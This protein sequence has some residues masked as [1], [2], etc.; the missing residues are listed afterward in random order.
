MKSVNMVKHSS[1]TTNVEA[2]ASPDRRGSSSL[3]QDLDCDD[4]NVN[5][6]NLGEVADCETEENSIVEVL[7]DVGDLTQD[8]NAEHIDVGS[9]DDHVK[10]DAYKSDQIDCMAAE[11][12]TS[13]AI[14][15]ELSNKI[16][17]DNYES[18]LHD[19]SDSNII[20]H[21]GFGMEYKLMAGKELSWVE[22]NVKLLDAFGGP[23]GSVGTNSDAIKK[24][25]NKDHVCN[26]E[27]SFEPGCVFIEYGRTEAS[28]NA[29]HCLHGRLFDDRVISVQYISLDI[30]HTR[31]PK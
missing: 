6:N 12:S 9:A 1:C 10:D 2:N 14:V 3:L 13:N 16:K 25:D 18:I 21:E 24:D 31:F 27:Q 28:C 19:I 23:H 11:V 4:T 30:Y 5:M 17:S 26:L 20:H 7:R 8:N 29:A 15:Q 22:D